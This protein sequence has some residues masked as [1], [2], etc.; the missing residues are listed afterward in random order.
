MHQSFFIRATQTKMFKLVVLSALFAAVVATPDILLTYKS[1]VIKPATTTISKQ[2][3]SVIH[4]SP[5]FY[6]PLVYSAIPEY[7]HLIKKRSVPVVSFVAPSSYVAPAQLTTYAA[8]P[9]LS[10]HLASPITTYSSPFFSTS[11]IYS[12]AHLIKKRSASFLVPSTYTAPTFYSARSYLPTYTYGTHE[13]ARHIVP[14]TSV[15]YGAHFIKK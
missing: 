7:A 15:V 8:A 4:P 14:S 10:T 5:A 6:S 11:P 9:I 12:T 1:T 3:S 2:A 13:I